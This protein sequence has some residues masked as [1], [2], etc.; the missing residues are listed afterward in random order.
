MRTTKWLSI[1]AALIFIASCFFPWVVI[2]TKNIVISGVS[3]EGTR[4]GK[5]GYLN[6]VFIFIVLVLS[7]F[8]KSWAIRI[9]L[10]LAACN[11]GWVLRNFILLSACEGGECPQR[12]PALFVYLVSAILLLVLI[13]LQ[14][15]KVQ[16]SEPANDQSEQSKA[17]F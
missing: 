5:P 2:E 7:F 16:E 12:Q 1:V 10:F 9:N 13:P 4:Y 15:V 14:K 8:Q 3:A 17:G 6:L 11:F